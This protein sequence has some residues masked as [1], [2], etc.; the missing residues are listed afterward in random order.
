MKTP[1]IFDI[2]KFVSTKAFGTYQTD[3]AQMSFAKGYIFVHMLKN[4]AIPPFYTE[5]LITFT[6]TKFSESKS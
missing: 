5:R 1:Y 4:K 6:S 2:L 3:K